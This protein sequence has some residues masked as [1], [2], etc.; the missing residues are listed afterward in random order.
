MHHI[1]RMSTSS[2]HTR[3]RHSIIQEP[4]ADLGGPQGAMAPPPNGLKKIFFTPLKIFFYVILVFKELRLLD[5][6]PALEIGPE[7]SVNYPPPL[8]N[9]RN[10]STTPPRNRAGKLRQLPPP[11]S[12]LRNPSTTPPLEI[13]PEN[14][15][16]YPPPSNLRPERKFAP[17]P[18][19][20]FLDPPLSRTRHLS[21]N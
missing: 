3:V 7:N 19:I 21:I 17:P 9:L 8:S 11:P 2:Q 20:Q 5:Y 1:I 18:K 12:N 6:T 4:V 13:G 14:S 16:N 15:V 10:P